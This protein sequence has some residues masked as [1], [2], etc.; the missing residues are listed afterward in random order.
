MA[1]MASARWKSV[2][3]AVHNDRAPSDVEWD[4]YMALLR[5]LAD[6]LHGDISKIH[7]LTFTDGAAPNAAQRNR[8]REVLGGKTITAALLSNSMFVRGVIGI[9]SVFIKGGRVFNPVDWR[10]AM[11]YLFGNTEVP[12]ELLA[13]LASMNDQIGKC[14]SLDPL[15]AANPRQK[16]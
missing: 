8:L 5:G 7:G 1:N 13:I 2:I 11:T 16:A 12:A 9:L 15:L 14:Q 6:D 4:Q 3:I 10:S